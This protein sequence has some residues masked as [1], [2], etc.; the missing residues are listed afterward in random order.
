MYLNSFLFVLHTLLMMG[1]FFFLLKKLQL[2]LSKTEFALAFIAKVMAGCV[3]GF[4]FL[5][6]YHG[7]DTWKLHEASLKEYDLLIH[8][9]KKF[10]STLFEPQR[11]AADKFF[12]T[13]KSYLKDLGDHLLVKLLALFN[14]VSNSNYYVKVVLFSSVSIWGHYFLFR[15]FENF[16]AGRRRLLFIIVFLFPPLLFWE[17]GI[18]K[19]A[20][21][22]VGVTGTIWFFQK[23]ILYQKRY[24]Y[25]LISFLFL[26]L[27]II[28]RN[29]VGLSL[30]ITGLFYLA[31][32]LPFRR[33]YIIIA[34]LIIAFTAFFSTTQLN[35]AYNLPLKIAERQA[36]FL[37][38]KGGSYVPTQILQPTMMGY[39][40]NLPGAIDHVLFR[41]YLTDIKSPLILMA[42]I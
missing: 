16:Y 40:S 42:G 29:F 18:R 35:D 21:L 19:D 9:S 20:L 26:I 15:I 22:F 36:A 3:Y 11:L 33:S 31:L 41:P 6:F 10:W 12:A 8:Q 13:D 37:A 5:K 25:L 24:Y 34:F 14:L 2:P 7:D 38:L 27:T 28:T 32:R 4:L 39:L 23:F 17:S 30:M 1:L